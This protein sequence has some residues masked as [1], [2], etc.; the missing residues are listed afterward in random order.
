MKILHVT[1]SSSGGA[2]IGAN[3]LH[4]ELIKKNINSKIFY[5]DE[6]IKNKSLIKNYFFFKFKWQL[7]VL[8]KK[9]ILKF[10]TKRI[11]RETTSFNLINILRIKQ[12]PNYN[13]ADIIHLHWIGNEMLSIKEI[14]KIDKNII[15]TLHDEWPISGIEHFSFDNRN[16]NQYSKSTKNIKEYGI[17][18]DR[19]VWL[20]KKKYLEKKKI[21]FIAPSKWVKKR[22][23]KSKLYKNYNII[24]IPNIQNLKKW[25]GTKK[26]NSKKKVLLFSATSSVNY[27]KG[28]NY[29]VDA[30]N[31]HL[32][33]NKY[34]LH[35][36][37][38]K[39]KNFEKINCDKKFIG[40]INSEKDLK[41]AYQKADIFILPSIA[42]T[43]G[44]VLLEVGAMGIPSVC[45]RDTAAAEVI[46]HKKNGYLAK[47]KSSEDLAC[48][49]EWCSEN[50]LNTKKTEMIK[51]NILNK[52]A[53]SNLIR[54]YIK[55]YKNVAKIY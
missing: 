2:A 35:V 33:T 11:N 18:F 16:I 49:I 15:W 29:L 48:G 38:D 36:I 22:F 26:I 45:F 50:L 5:F 8:L 34:A 37:G 4:K 55:F 19:I 54:K 6:Y 27:R 25:Q 20:I 43:F 44:Q 17:D 13:G 32:D 10:L 23:I 40:F 28:F 30:I 14:S 24:Q 31:N 21:H 39:P 1:F 7:T 52:Y 47:F 46:H 12:I 3:R 41:K 42:E 53:P 51:K 9:I